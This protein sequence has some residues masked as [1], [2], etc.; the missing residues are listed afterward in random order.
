MEPLFPSLDEPELK[1]KAPLTPAAPAFVL[2]ILTVPLVVAVPSPLEILR[3]PPVCTVLRPE[4]T[5]AT[6]PAPL[7]PL[8]TV[9]ES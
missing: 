2:R 6:P 5:D 7:V 4:N 3:A 8:P 1:S 9:S